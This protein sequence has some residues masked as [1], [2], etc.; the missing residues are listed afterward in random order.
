MNG[1]EIGNRKVGNGEA[2]FI[3]AEA[4]VNHNG[5]LKKAKRLVDAAAKA[6]ADAVKFQ[7]YRAKD[8]VTEQAPKAEYQ[9]AGT[10]T[11]ETQLQMLSN[12]L[13]FAKPLD[14]RVI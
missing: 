9:K 12:A 14:F 7:T 4:G 13:L 10:E 6:G 8:L 3:V 11:G 2:C 5:D 1:G